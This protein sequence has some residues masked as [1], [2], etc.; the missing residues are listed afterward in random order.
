MRMIPLLI[1]VFVGAAGACEISELAPSISGEQE[2]PVVSERHAF[3]VNNHQIYGYDL[4]QHAVFPVDIIRY[5]TEVAVDTPFVVWVGFNEDSQIYLCD[6]RRTGGSG[7]CLESDEKHQVTNYTSLKKNVDVRGHFLVWQDHA[8]GNWDIVLCDLRKNGHE[9]GCLAG[10]AKM[11]VTNDLFDQI[12]PSVD[13]RW[14]VWEDH[15]GDAG[16]IYG[17]NL[18]RG[19]EVPFVMREGRQSRP[20][21]RRSSVFFEDNSDG[22]FEIKELSLR[23]GMII[24]LTRSSF[25]EVNPHV[26]R[27]T[28]V[29]ETSRFGV[30]SIEVFDLQSSAN[31]FLKLRDREY[32]PSVFGKHIV[33]ESA[34]NGTRRV[35]L[36]HCL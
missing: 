10:D 1:L 34:V 22:N 27:H 33:F 19:V 21:V 30:S 35:F 11:F 6:L 7:G 24:T 5:S 3:W 14:I 23:D 28:L 13:G 29:Y 17:Y 36:D 15:R 25:D 4:R 9:G 20:V 31:R 26:D 18:L 32:N 12:E 2:L 8:R 16:D